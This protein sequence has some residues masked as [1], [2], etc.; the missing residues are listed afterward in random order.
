[1]NLTTLFRL[2]K[3]EGTDPVDVKDFNDNFDVI[4]AE[5]GKRPEK[6]GN[7][8]DM[9]TAFSQAGSRTNL[10]SGEKLSV[11]MGKIMKWFADLKTVAFT[12][13]YADLTGKPSIP[14]GTAASQGVANNCTTTAAGYVLDARQG[15]TLMDK[16]N[17]LSSDLSRVNVY[18]GSDGKLHY[19]NK[20]GADSAL[21]FSP[22]VADKINDFIG[23]SKYVDF[24]TGTG[25]TKNVGVVSGAQY[26]VCDIGQYERKIKF[27]SGCNIN[28]SYQVPGDQ[29]ADRVPTE[30][31]IT[32]TSTTIN[33]T[34]SSGA[35]FIRIK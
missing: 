10:T 7:A 34:G 5:L 18:V 14:S 12:G 23:S 8:S 15:K 30:Y 35:F 27:N 2:R 20:D 22:D 13:S 1:M 19:V 25:N 17:Q 29:N 6:T 4:D 28:Y 21:P 26:L 11:S 3:P 16:A 31:I 33:V 32:A 24:F 9:V